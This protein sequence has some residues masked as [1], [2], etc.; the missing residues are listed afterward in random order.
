MTRTWWITACAILA[1]A[2]IGVG[3]SWYEYAGDRGFGFSKPLISDDTDSITP[4]IP[5]HPAGRARVFIEGDGVFDFGV[6]SKSE[7]RQH[8]FVVQNT[9]TIPLKL[10]FLEKS[11]Q[12]TDVKMSR[13]EVPPGDSAEIELSW[14]PN[15]YK[16]EFA[17]TARFVTNDP[18]RLELDL[19]VQGRVQQIVRPVPIAVSFGNVLSDES[20][21]TQIDVFGY[22]DADLRVEKVEFLQASSADF[23]EATSEPL[24][25][26]VLEREPGALWNVNRV[27]RVVPE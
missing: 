25:P 11:C 20:R 1:G 26:E 23:L 21:E 27:L 5:T 6:M 13:T 7:T 15:D 12:C 4:T 18:A 24:R 2:A 10:R 16:L 3:S 19:T 9:G 17:Q 8:T 22:R 14:Q